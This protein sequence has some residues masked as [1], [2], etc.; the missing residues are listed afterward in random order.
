MK[1]SST[2]REA[3]VF[4]TLLSK[5]LFDF[6]PPHDLLN[7]LITEFLNSS[8]HHY[9]ESVAFVLFKFFDLLQ[10]KDLHAEIQEWC[11]ST[12]CSARASTSPSGSPLFWSGAPHATSGSRPFSRS[13]ST[14]TARSS[15]STAP[16]STWSRYSSARSLDPTRRSSRVATPPSSRCPARHALCR[17]P[18]AQCMNSANT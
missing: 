5:M 7:K 18:H 16:S 13:C 11:I 3:I 8:Q 12:S 17:T 15:T 10:K 6:L 4:A 2:A 14:A 9:P 1:S